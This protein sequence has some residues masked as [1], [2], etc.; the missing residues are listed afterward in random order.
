MRHAFMLLGLLALAAEADAQASDPFAAYEAFKQQAQQSY[1]SFRQQCMKDYTDF[2]RQAWDAFEGNAPIPQPEDDMLPPVTFP[3]DDE[4][5]PAPNPQVEPELE[6]K[7]IVIE[8]IITP[9]PVPP[10]PE[11][12]EPIIERPKPLAETI[13]F[14]FFGTSASVRHESALSITLRKASNHAIADALEQL[15]DGRSENMLYDCLALRTNHNLCDWS[16]LTMLKELSASIYGEGTNEAVLL[17]AYLYMQ[18][19]YKMRLAE[20]KGKLYMLFATDHYLYN[21]IGY[22]KDGI[23]YFGFDTLPSHLNI[24]RASFPKERSMSLLVSSAQV[25]AV[26]AS[27]RCER[28]SRRYPAF[29]ATVA[30][31]KNWLDF[32]SSYPTSMIGNNFMTRWAMYANTPMAKD[33]SEQLYPQFR[34][35]LDGKSQLDAVNILLNWVQTG[36]EYEYDDKVW[37]GDRAFFAEESLNY[38]YCDCEDR[39]ILFTRLVR[40]LLGLKC[41]LVFYPGHLAAAVNFTEMVN[42]DYIQLNGQRYIVSD[43]TYIGAPVGKTMPNMDNQS[44]KVI[45]LE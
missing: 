36:F 14:K 45:L 7:P 34:P 32:C 16:Y 2:V 22:T 40:D 26:E 28:K 4:Q 29:K 19:G 41:I 43:P 30:V 9:L 15:D 1:A 21:R 10:Q 27:L 20:S 12:V 23:T 37:G 5:K 3:E 31:N 38:P 13:T 25:L 35:L 33:V 17:M 24:C 18:S 39:S 8:E 6:P 11:P 42:G 44:A